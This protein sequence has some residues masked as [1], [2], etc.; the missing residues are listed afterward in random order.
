MR[1]TRVNGPL[2]M[3]AAGSQ[4]NGA[5]TKIVEASTS[6]LHETYAG[7]AADVQGQNGWTGGGVT[8]EEIPGKMVKTCGGRIEIVVV[9]K[10]AEASR[11]GIESGTHSA[12]A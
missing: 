5:S 6:W 9:D 7:V 3:R 1:E 4:A 11:S 10:V 2:D 8:I 12:K